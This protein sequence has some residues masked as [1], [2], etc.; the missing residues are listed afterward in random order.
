MV[1]PLRFRAVA[2][3]AKLFARAE[4]RQGLQHVRAGAEKFTVQFAQ[5]VGII[6]GDFGC[7]LSA[8][9]AGADLLAPRTAVHIAAPFEF[10]EI[11]AVADS[12]AFFQEF[13][14]GLFHV[15]RS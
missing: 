5:S 9:A 10:D 1:D 3:A 8:A 7:E 15:I 4:E 13:S 11:A 2:R 14:N 6:D 12:D